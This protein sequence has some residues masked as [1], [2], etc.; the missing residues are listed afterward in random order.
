MRKPAREQ[1]LNAQLGGQ[2][3]DSQHFEQALNAQ[4]SEQGLYFQHDDQA[5]ANA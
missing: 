4:L 2:G 1:G 5:L 3:H